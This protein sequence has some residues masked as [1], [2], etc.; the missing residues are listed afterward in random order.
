MGGAEP[1]PGSM[2]A[3]RHWLDPDPRQAVG[4][5]H[6]DAATASELLRRAVG[7]P[8]FTAG[9]EPISSRPSDRRDDRPR[10]PRRRRRAHAIW[11]RLV[12]HAHRAVPCRDLDGRR[13][14]LHVHRRPDAVVL[15]F[16]APGPLTLTSRQARRLRTILTIDAS[17]QGAGR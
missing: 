4:A 11:A 16:S 17:Q 14:R 3:A 12:P 15:S 6:R 5:N 8:P 1:Q 2:W 9:A 13:T 7:L 10:P